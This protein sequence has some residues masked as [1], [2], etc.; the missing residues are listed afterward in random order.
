[1][2]KDYNEFRANMKTG[3]D[4]STE[5][6]MFLKKAR[7]FTFSEYEKRYQKEKREVADINKRR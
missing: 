1:M 6:L 7:P 5:N 4:K 2:I 3:T